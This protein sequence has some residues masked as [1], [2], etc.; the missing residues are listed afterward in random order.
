MRSRNLLAAV[1]AAVVYLLFDTD[2]AL[3]WGPGVHVALASEVLSRAAWLP[4]AVAGLITRYGRD[5]LYG[6]LAADL[7]FAKRLSRVKQFCHHWS[8]G[9]TV[10]DRARD[11]QG[12]AFAYG[13]LSHLAADTVAHGKFV[14]HQIAVTRTTVSFGHL[15]WEM[16]ADV[17]VGSAVWQQVDEALTGDH[18]DHHALLAELLTD[19]F[20]PFDANRQLFT[21][22]NRLVGR[23]S[24]Q[25]TMS[26]W[27]RR[28]R[29]D[30]P[31]TLLDGFLAESLDRTM[32]LLTSLCRSPVLSED[33][34]GTAA[35]AYLRAHRRQLRR[36]R[37]RGLPPGQRVW[38]T[39]ASYA[40]ATRPTAAPATAS[41]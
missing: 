32:C 6:N 39:A 16:R 18:D 8:T 27:E 14:P 17:T 30:L 28:S 31:S 38:E 41:P 5:Y 22:L 40:P 15:Y 12:R 25:R 9:F 37:R 29:H 21:G 10:L 33:P 34:N 36:L 1:V 35:L 2:V 4:A 20:L 13:Y 3:A 26:M 11:D 24:W 23:K 7:V 19:T